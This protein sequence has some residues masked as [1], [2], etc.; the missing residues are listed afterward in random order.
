MPLSQSTLRWLQQ[1]RAV[2]EEGTGD[3][4]VTFAGSL[5]EPRTTGLAQIRLKLAEFGI[6]FQVSGRL[7]GGPRVSNEDYWR[8]LLRAPVSLT[9]TGQVRARGLDMPEVNQMVYRIT[10]ALACRSVL[11][12]EAVPGLSDYFVSG[13]HLETFQ[14]VDEAVEKI[15][16]LKRQ[17]SRTRDLAARGFERVAQFVSNHVFWAKIE[18]QL[19]RSLVASSQP[20]NNSGVP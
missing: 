16:R 12:S 18:D 7:P 1:E 8:I 19:E 11:V 13:H 6:D 4:A 3:W 2:I 15:L 17:P 5:Y 14:S 10:E 20:D 9:T